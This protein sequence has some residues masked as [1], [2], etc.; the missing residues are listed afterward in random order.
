MECP[1]DYATLS[2]FL[3]GLAI[4]FC[5]EHAVFLQEFLTLRARQAPQCIDGHRLFCVPASGGDKQCVLVL[6]R[7]S[8]CQRITDPIIGKRSVGV[9]SSHPEFKE[10]SLGTVHMD[11][12]KVTNACRQSMEELV[13]LISSVA[14]ES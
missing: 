7:D 6:H 4:A 5:A 9:L 8:P 1:G 3:W 13:G 14:S 12:Y 2:Y 11:P 10:T